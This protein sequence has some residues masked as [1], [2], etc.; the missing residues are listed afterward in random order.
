[1]FVKGS[2]L[3]PFA[4][5]QGRRETEVDMFER[6]GGWRHGGRG[7]GEGSPLMTPRL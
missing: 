2:N 6:Y 4:V 1:M 3:E 7:Q 5:V